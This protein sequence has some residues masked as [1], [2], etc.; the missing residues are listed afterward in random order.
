MKK[1]LI[2]GLFIIGLLLVSMISCSHDNDFIPE[3]EPPAPPAVIQKTAYEVFESLVNQDLPN[4]NFDNLNMS[5]YYNY[6][7]VEFYSTFDPTPNPNEGQSYHF[8]DLKENSVILETK[9]N[10]INTEGLGRSGENLS[11]LNPIPTGKPGPTKIEL[12]ISEESWG[13]RMVGQ[14]EDGDKT[15]DI[16]VFF[17]NTDN[18]RW[19]N[20]EKHWYYYKNEFNSD[21]NTCIDIDV[22]YTLKKSCKDFIEDSEY[23]WTPLE[24]QCDYASK[25]V[26]SSP[27]TFKAAEQSDDNLLNSLQFALNTP[28]LKL[29]EYGF[30]NKNP[31]IVSV[32]TM[33]RMIWYGPFFTNGIM[34]SLYPVY[35][36]YE[37]KVRSLVKTEN[38][39]NGS[40]L[41]FIEGDDKV[42]FYVNVA[43]LLKIRMLSDFMNENPHVDPYAYYYPLENSK[44]FDFLGNI[45]IALGDYAVNG[46]TTT[47]NASVEI[48]NSTPGWAPEKSN[49]SI[50]IQ[51]SELS[52]RLTMCLLNMVLQK[53]NL[54]RINEYWKNNGLSESEIHSLNSDLISLKTIDTDFD[55]G[56]KS[57]GNISVWRFSTLD[58]QKIYNIMQGKYIQ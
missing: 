47:L 8:Y 49:L 46:I 48:E 56:I 15:I 7:Y 29:S 6:F 40:F 52:R 38:F 41:Y 32:A 11:V 30:G 39:P 58:A 57:A 51:D 27:F 33:F 12:S 1:E 36:N 55:F 22:K 18:E 28:C 54:A 44:I 24:S 53:E 23:T 10:V 21:K 17:R 43:K 14:Y 34:T 4:D 2:Y 3:P 20:F 25:N 16:T 50:E 13:L 9:G 19:Y 26:K 45:A 35:A 42:T 31:N 37:Y 5:Y